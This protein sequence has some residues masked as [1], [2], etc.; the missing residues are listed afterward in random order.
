MSGSGTGN[1]G[2]VPEQGNRGTVG[3]LD[4]FKDSTP[5]GFSIDDH[6]NIR[7]S[8]GTIVGHDQTGL[9][10][11]VS[12]LDSE[13]QSIGPA[14]GAL[15]SSDNSGTQ[16]GAGIQTYVADGHAVYRLQS[17]DN[18]RVLCGYAFGFGAPWVVPPPAQA[19]WEAD[20]LHWSNGGP[21]GS[22]GSTI[23]VPTAEG[24]KSAP[25]LPPIR[26]LP[27]LNTDGF[28]LGS[29]GYLEDASTGYMT[30][31]DMTGKTCQNCIS[32]WI[33]YPGIA[34]AQVIHLPWGV[35]NGVK[36]TGFN[37]YLQYVPAH[38]NPNGPGTDGSH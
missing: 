27:E 19:V 18:N 2:G 38:V 24:W 25:G 11:A 6:G 30:A 10:E 1:T 33:A 8:T 34:G 7:D 17:T 20:G 26:I 37:G 28:A 14:D 13:S 15:A 16:N 5:G 21:L 32:M 35:I 23:L 12:A 4:P 29:A 36:E 31:L 3:P 22:S 9:G